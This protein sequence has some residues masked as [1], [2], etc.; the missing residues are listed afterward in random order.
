[1]LERPR[2]SLVAVSTHRPRTLL[3]A[4]HAAGLEFAEDDLAEIARRTLAEMGL[5]REGRK[6][7]DGRTDT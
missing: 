7:S 3:E 2:T 1:M 4:F 6:G 5:L